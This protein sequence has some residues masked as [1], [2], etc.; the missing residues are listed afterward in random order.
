MITGKSFGTGILTTVNPPKTGA[1]TNTLFDSMYR[2]FQ[3]DGDPLNERMQQPENDAA[4]YTLVSKFGAQRQNPLTN[5]AIWW[6]VENRLNMF[7]SLAK[8]LAA[9]DTYASVAQPD[10]LRAGYTI[11]LPQTGEM[12]VVLSVD[13]DLSEG[14]TNL[15][16]DAANVKLDRTGAGPH[17]AASIGM[18]VR[19]GAPRMGEQ[20]EPKN[21]IMTVP[22]D[23]MFNL[24]QLFGIQISSTTMQRNSLM[25]SDYGT[26]ER[27]VRENE[28]YLAQL[29]QTTM[30]LGRRESISTAD[31]GMVYMTNGLIPQLK[32]NVL[33]AGSVGNTLTYGNVSEF[34]DGTFESANSFST[35]YIPCGELL[36]VNLLNTAR[37][38][39]K[40]VD[41]P[42]YNPAL[43]VDE[44]KMTTAGGKTVTIAKLRFAFMGTLKDWG[45]VLDMPNIGVGEYA[46]FGWKWHTNLEAPMQAITK[47]T[48]AL[49]GS[50]CL[51]V[52]DPDTCGVIRG[53]TNPLV[54][55][56]NGLGVVQ[57]Y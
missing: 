44:F 1:G 29:L 20:G 40:L 45:L 6:R 13:S 31:E 25:A 4:L 24:I 32:D 27:L 47:K 50:I 42:M 17:L 26:H 56:R 14:W 35:K 37:Q 3:W 21:G 34:V 55:N 22:G 36:F 10:L 12:A 19:A 41:G 46:G 53:G 49:I 11:Y 8:A 28:A 15:A 9:G 5:P 23:P 16:S 48:D 51:T 7:T 52:R 57:N 43:G 33:S 39:A 30:L 2:P 18:E 54:A 38:E